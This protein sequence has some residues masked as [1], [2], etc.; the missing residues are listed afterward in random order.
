MMF[1]S[2][3]IAL[4]LIF[5][6]GCSEQF[7]TDPK[8]LAAKKTSTTGYGTVGSTT[9]GTT[10]GTTGSTTGSTTGTTTGSTTG[11]TGTT[12]GSTT[13]STGST[14]SS[15]TGTTSGGNTGCSDSYTDAFCRAG[16]QPPNVM[17]TLQALAS[18]YPGEL[19]RCGRHEY[20]F[21]HLA[22]TELRKTDER[23][24]L[25]WVR[26]NYGDETGDTIAYYYG[27]GAPQS[28]STFTVVIDFIAGCEGDNESIYWGAYVP[29][30]YNACCNPPAT[31]RWTIEPLGGS[32]TT[33]STTG[34]SSICLGTGGQVRNGYPD[35][36][37]CNASWGNDPQYT[38][39]NNIDGCWK[40]KGF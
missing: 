28:N 6:I 34:T 38:P 9:G 31:A 8:L 22:V 33:G 12:T 7:K 36:N 27:P 15:T 20:E 3:L 1:R 29:A 16:G 18:Q 19:S 5:L 26:G 11:S 25:N 4:G 35:A 37:D 14:T 30:D 10:G 24:G 32:S 23:W 39:C 21:S 40:P 2:L 17:G 13:G